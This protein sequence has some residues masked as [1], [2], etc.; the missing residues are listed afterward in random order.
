MDVK[1]AGSAGVAAG[2][3]LNFQQLLQS[4]LFSARKRQETSLGLMVAMF[5]VILLTNLQFSSASEYQGIAQLMC[6]VAIVSSLFGPGLAKQADRLANTLQQQQVNGELLIVLLIGMLMTPATL[7]TIFAFPS[8]HHWPLVLAMALSVICLASIS[9]AH[10]MRLIFLISPVVIATVTNLSWAGESVDLL[11]ALAITSSVFATVIWL[12]QRHRSLVTSLVARVNEQMMPIRLER[13]IAAQ[14]REIDQ[15]ILVNR[16]GWQDMEKPAQTIASL[17]QQLDAANSGNPAIARAL[18][19]MSKHVSEQTHQFGRWAGS[20]AGPHAP[21]PEWISVASLFETI[22]LRL[23]AQAQS[24]GARLQFNPVAADLEAQPGLVERTVQNLIVH[25]MID[26]NASSILVNARFVGQTLSVIIEHDGSPPSQYLTSPDLLRE[27]LPR[28]LALASTAGLLLEI[29]DSKRTGF[30]LSFDQ[31]RKHPPHT[32]VQPRSTVAVPSAN[33]ASVDAGVNAGVKCHA[34]LI[35]DDPLARMGLAA[36][37][38]Q[39]GY[40]TTIWN[41]QSTKSI[42]SDLAGA[43]INFIV[44]DWW[45][46]KN[47]NA[48]AM[49]KWVQQ[50]LPTP[51]P[52]VIVSGDQALQ[53]APTISAQLDSIP[54]RTLAKPVTP[55]TLARAINDLIELDQN[56][57]S[58]RP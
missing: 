5:G 21:A 36:L 33:D 40:D 10:P 6:V 50:S 2:T 52:V 16:A 13:M 58:S 38:E 49:L 48:I 45:L 44:S 22:R 26:A 51:V 15:Q 8:P 27:G 47:A 54:L 23:I 20:A 29:E 43:N 31:W 57:D 25:S 11:L 37:L 32:I 34:L 14:Q 12:R 30:T 17:A 35:D 18:V 39:A 3:A 9:D 55:K 24:S 46:G 41:G 28:A 53:D 56:F 1:K 4:S 19:H 42:E 7:L